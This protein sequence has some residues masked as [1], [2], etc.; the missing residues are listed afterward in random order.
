MIGRG[1]GPK[2]ATSISI[3]QKSGPSAE[4]FPPRGHGARMLNVFQITLPVFLMKPH[5]VVITFVALLSASTTASA[6]SITA[7]G[8][9]PAGCPAVRSPNVDHATTAD[10]SSRPDSSG[11]GLPEN[12]GT[13]DVILFVSFSADQ[14]RFNSQPNAAIRFCWGG[15]SLRVVERRNLP[16]PVVAG[17][18]YKDVYIAAELRMYLSPECLARAFG[19]SPD[20]ATGS[21]C[22]AIGVSSPGPTAGKGSSTIVTTVSKQVR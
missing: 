6:Q 16:S 17:T 18:S 21:S 10:S 3:S 13:P 15:D 2:K 5:A 14:L 22:A 7:A 9:N 11:L 4:P 8:S 1:G 19:P 12:G 20:I